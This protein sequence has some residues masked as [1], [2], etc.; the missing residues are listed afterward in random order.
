MHIDPHSLHLIVA[1]VMTFVG[2]TV[3]FTLNTAPTGPYSKSW[4]VVSSADADTTGSVSHGFPST[5]AMVWL[6]P[7][8]PQAYGKQWTLGTVSSTTIT[9]NGISSTSAGSTAAQ[10]QLIAMLPH[11]II[12]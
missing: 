3:S 12:D 5:P 6:V 1:I 9:I 10:L 8:L 11:S 4:Q 7:L 2:A